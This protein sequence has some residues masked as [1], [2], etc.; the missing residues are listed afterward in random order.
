MRFTLG[1]AGGCV[2]LALLV[3]WEFARPP[4]PEPPPILKPP[5]PAT[6]PPVPTWDYRAPPLAQ[7]SETVE[8]PL[9]MAERRPP[10]PGQQDNV[11][12]V[13]ARPLQR[14]DVRLLGIVITPE[15]RQ[16]LLQEKRGGNVLYLEPGMALD[17]WQVKTVDPDR[18]V[19][20]AAG[21][22]E[23]LE[24]RTFEDQPPMPAEAQPAPGAPAAASPQVRKREM[25]Q[26]KRARQKFRKN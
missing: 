14:P 17:D 10:A 26:A 1:L 25:R 15:R 16:A 22:T 23:E 20:A 12:P 24:L 18:V 7:F 3:A 8:R 13:A 21:E 4:A 9:F 6:L 19:L 2:I 5:A 11:P